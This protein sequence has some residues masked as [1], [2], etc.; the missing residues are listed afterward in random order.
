MKVLTFYKFVVLPDV[1]AL[2]ETLEREAAQLSLKGTILLSTE[3]INGTVAGTESSVHEFSEQLLRHEPFA[4]NR[5]HV[6]K[7]CRNQYYAGSLG[8]GRTRTVFHCT[9][10]GFPRLSLSEIMP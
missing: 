5:P 9:C 7:V 2:R 3:G 6:C 1:D 4:G 10:W 8:E